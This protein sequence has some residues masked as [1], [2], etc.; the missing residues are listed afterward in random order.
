MSSWKARD[1]DTQTTN[2]FPQPSNIWIRPRTP[3]KRKLASSKTSKTS[4][5]SPSPRTSR[6]RKLKLKN[7]IKFRKQ[8]TLTAVGMDMDNDESITLRQPEESKQ[9]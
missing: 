4:C 5:L 3:R 7:E 6:N 8:S 1:S 9:M 2:V